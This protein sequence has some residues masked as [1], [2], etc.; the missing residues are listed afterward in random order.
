[1]TV[2]RKLLPGR[3]AANSRL[4][5][6][7]L[8]PRRVVIR[9]PQ[10]RDRNSSRARPSALIDDDL[11]QPAKEASTTWVKLPSVLPSTKQGLLYDVLSGRVRRQPRGQPDK[12]RHV[13]ANEAREGDG[14]LPI[15]RRRRVGLSTT[16]HYGH[17]L[18]TRERVRSVGSPG[19]GWRFPPG[20][21]MDVISPGATG[22]IGRP[23]SRLDLLQR[24]SWVIRV[25][26]Q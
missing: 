12:S 4:Q 6:D 20:T 13:R 22:S 15:D 2:D 18:Y 9:G 5:V 8:V 24:E 11:G 21:Q 26:D 1:M 3:K 16:G 17:N 7:P 19:R 14:I 25:L 23:Q 10:R